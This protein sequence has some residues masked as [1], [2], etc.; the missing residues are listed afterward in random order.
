MIHHRERRPDTQEEKVWKR[1]IAWK[2]KWW[3]INCGWMTTTRIAALVTPLKTI[4]SAICDSI[5]VMLIVTSTTMLTH[6]HSLLFYSQIPK[7]KWRWTAS[8]AKRADTDDPLKRKNRT[9]FNGQLLWSWGEL[10]YCM[11]IRL[12]N[13]FYTDRHAPSFQN[14]NNFNLKFR[15]TSS[16]AAQLDTHMS[17]TWLNHH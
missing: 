7:G 14:P 12:C 16:V 9:Q 11:P 2:W 1:T 3:T 15:V 6:L 4:A 10:K 17:F 5:L 8:K 13:T